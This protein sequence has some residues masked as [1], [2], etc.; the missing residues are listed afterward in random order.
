MDL[1]DNDVDLEIK[2]FVAN[3]SDIEIDRYSDVGCN[4]DLYFGKHKI[5]NERVALKFY[6]T[7]SKGISHKEPQILR[8]IDHPNII[9]VHDARKISDNYAYFLTSEFSGGD[10]HKYIKENHISTHVALSI[11]Q[12]ILKGVNEMHKK[13][14]RLLHRDLKPNNILIDKESKLACIADFGSI[15]YIP[16]RKNSIVASKNSL[17]YRPKESIQRNEYNFQSDVYQVGL[18]LFQLLGGFF[19]DAMIDWFNEKQQNKLKKIRDI[20]EQ[21]LFTESVFDNLI[22]KNKLLRIE[23]LPFYIDNRLKTIIRKATRP[24]L[25][26]RYKSASEFMNALY[27]YKTKS[28]DWVSADNEY[29]AINSKKTCFRIYNSRKGFDVER[30]VKSGKA[31]KMRSHDNSLENIYEL[32]IND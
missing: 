9:K 3:Q 32:I 11:T 10:L 22:V 8:G 5:F 17:V 26:K 23:S 6:Y 7:D 14:N 12:D 16:A 30:T 15:K 25:S 1:K 27:K 31:R 24:E 28:I 19:P 2:E 18:I 13:P 21:H 29:L 20:F 4:G